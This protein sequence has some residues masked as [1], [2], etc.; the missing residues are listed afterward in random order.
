VRCH[1]TK[2][3]EDAKA[4]EYPFETFAQL[5][6]RVTATASSAMSLTKLAQSTHVHL[7]GFSMLYGLTGLILAFSSYPTWLR[8]LLCP[9]PLLAQIADISFW[10]LA[11]LPEELH[12]PE[13]ARLIAISGAVVAVG[14][15]LHLVLS[16]FDLFGRGGK[17]IL[18]FLFI[19]VG[20]GAGTLVGGGHLQEYLQ[21]EK[22]GK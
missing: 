22:A 20:F 7:L 21:L 4:S 15:L 16:L 13:F 17:V 9:L 3:S 5:K 1:T 19:A 14:L 6:P 11:R 2:D 12:G 18:L 10:W 8:V